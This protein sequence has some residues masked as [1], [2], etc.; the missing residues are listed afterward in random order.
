M[1]DNR[2][3]MTLKPLRSFVVIMLVSTNAA[4][5]AA[6]DEAH[7]PWVEP[8]EPIWDRALTVAAEPMVSM[9]LGD[10]GKV[11]GIGVG[12]GLRLEYWP[13]ARVRL[14]ARGGYVF[15]L[16]KNEINTHELTALGGVELFVRPGQPEFL[17]FEG[18]VSHLRFTSAELDL[19]FG[20]TTDPA[21]GAGAGYD[22]GRL[23][24]RLGVLFP[25]A[26]EPGAGFA[27]TAVLTVRAFGAG[28]SPLA[29]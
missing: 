20:P 4:A 13:V 3:A 22:A 28:S 9:P 23:G 27:I 11:A 8:S 5:P 7:E 2:A 1:A 17:W 12:A 14:L 29:R 21:A 18:G 24:V 19:D 26:H 6:A 16:V 15:H 10:F 25:V